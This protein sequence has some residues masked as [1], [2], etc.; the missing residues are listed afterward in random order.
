M[1]ELSVP[2][3][4]PG[5]VLIQVKAARI[6]GTDPHIPV[7]NFPVFPAYPLIPG[8]EFA[9]VVAEMGSVALLPRWPREDP[10]AGTSL[11]RGAQI[12]L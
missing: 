4:K 12:R 7:G 2:K 8:H 10:A 5:E 11:R 3:P 1:K 6:C 9:G